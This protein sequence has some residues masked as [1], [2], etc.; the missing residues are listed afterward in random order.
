MRKTTR[1]SSFVRLTT[2]LMAIAFLAA[3]VGGSERPGSPAPASEEPKVRRLVMSVAAPGTESNSPRLNSVTDMWQIRPMYEH[4]IGIDPQ[5]GGFVPQLATEWSVEPDGKSFRF[6]LRRGVQFHGGWGEFTA[7]DVVHSWQDTIK[8]DAP[9]AQNVL[10]RTIV[11]QIEV[12][13]EYE[14]VFHL[15]RPDV[16]FESVVSEI[17]SGLM[18]MSRDHFDAAGDPTLFA[19]PI[20]GTGPYQ[21]KERAQGSF[22]RFERVPFPH[23]RGTPDFPEFEFRYQNEASSRLASLLTG[24]AQITNLPPDLLPQAESQGFKII[25]GRVQSVRTFISIQCC[26][27]ETQTGAYPA[28]PN[29]PLLDVKVRR[30]LNKAVNRAELNRAFFAGKGEIMY[31]NHFHPTREGWDPSWVARFEDEYGYEPAKA[32]ALL[33]EV[34]QPGLRTS[35]IIRPLPNFSGA[36]DVSEAIAGYWRAIGVDVQLLQIDGA[37]IVA[38]QR[39]LKYDNHFL[40]VGTSAPQTNGFG[41]YNTSVFGNYLGFQHPDLQAGIKRVQVELDAAKRGDLWR[42]LGNR[43][44]EL[45]PDIPLFWLPAEAVVNPQVVADYVWPGS[46]TGTWTHPQNIKAARS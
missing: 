44:Y 13:N 12:V 40:I 41:V 3:C 26:F 25:P 18:I 39:T 4:L 9:G 24:E 35:M 32:R 2:G 15:H 5:S 11:D 38:A 7:K 36:E 21:F 33:A 17:R 30:A 28:H 22:I 10:L 43:A 45:H 23:W 34:G 20:A 29:S 46:L 6:K 8:E 42:Q 31:L 16:D 19:P 1:R 14:V 27:V 37:E